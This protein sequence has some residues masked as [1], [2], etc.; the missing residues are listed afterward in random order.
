[1]Q[2]SLSFI[3]KQ[4]ATS[5]SQ[6]GYLI[7]VPGDQDFAQGADFLTEIA[8][9]NSFKFLMTNAANTTRIPHVK[10]IIVNAGDKKIY[11]MGVTAPSVLQVQHRIFFNDPVQ[12][13]ATEI[14]D[15]KNQKAEGDLIFLIS[16]SGMDLDQKYASA[17]PEIDWIIGAHTMNFNSSPVI[18]GK[19]EITQVLSR[20]HYLG[21]IEI[22]FGTNQ[23][24]NYSLLESREE[25]QDLIN[26]NPMKKFLEDHKQTLMQI[27]QEEQKMMMSSNGE[28]NLIATAQSCMECHNKQTE[29]WQKT[30][31]SIAYAT[32][33]KNNAHLNSQCIECHSVGFQKEN[34]FQRPMDIV[35]HAKKPL[36][37][38]KYMQELGRVFTNIKTVRDATAT[39]IKVIRTDW[40]KLDRKF[41]V[42]HNFANVQCLNCHDQAAEHPFAIEEVKTENYQSKCIQC[43]TLDQSPDWY[44]KNSNKIDATKFKQHLKQVA[45]P[46]GK[47]QI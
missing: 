23:P 29:F 2:K 34:G 7:M 5:M 39:Q 17:F 13:L 22:P 35:F 18:E 19:T 31:H 27:Q 24:I 38:P 14:K 3:A 33:Y 43:H 46:K 41:K 12:A 32:L 8:Q 47:A 16:H 20:N 4:I 21:K 26:P 40:N 44:V 11:F 10:K 45:C 36:E 30:K 25:T 9:Q 42:E 37:D 6:M 1:M 28:L 15:I